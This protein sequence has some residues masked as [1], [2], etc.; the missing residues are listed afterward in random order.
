MLEF[1]EFNLYLIRHG[2]STINIIPDHMG[3][4]S[5]TPLTD[6]GRHQAHLLGQRLQKEV[7]DFHH[8][9]SSHYTRA[10]DTA[11]IALPRYQDSI[12]ICPDLREY[13][14]G[15]WEGSKRSEVMTPQVALRMGYM[16]SGF[17]PPNGESM[18]QV[19]R[20]VSRWMEDTILYNSQIQ[21][22]AYDYRHVHY[23][24]NSKHPN[25]NIAVFS[26]G[27]TI[28]CLLH[29]IMGFDQSFIWKLTL[30][31]TSICKLVFNQEGWRLITIN[32]HAHLL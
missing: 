28:K 7:G 32:D 20:R 24:N 6:H 26:H 30:E 2:Q 11:K 1:N 10:H 17:Q 25:M 31:N 16:A 14:A 3:Q 15:A 22:E 18:H 8:I 21:K 13:S 5:D 4:K 12:V 23:P 9:F 29:H 27:M 19:E